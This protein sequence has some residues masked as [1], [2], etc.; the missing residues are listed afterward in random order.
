MSMEQFN[1]ML[2]TQRVSTTLLLFD[3][4]LQTLKWG[5]AQPLAKFS[6]FFLQ[7]PM[8]ACGQGTRV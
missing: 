5:D 7:M 3:G 4:F 2:W 6:L 8:L 1:E